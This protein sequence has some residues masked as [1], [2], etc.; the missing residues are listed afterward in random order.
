MPDEQ[1][2]AP[3]QTNTTTTPPANGSA[4]STNGSTPAGAE[5]TGREPMIPRE[6]FDDVN[7][8]LKATEAELKKLQDAA[9][10]AER[11]RQAAEAKALADQGEFKKLYET[12]SGELETAKARAKQADAL[13]A[14]IREMVDTRKANVP[15]HLKPLIEKLDPVEALRWLDAN[16]DK[17][18][19]N[20]APGTNAGERGERGKTPVDP[21][22]VLRRQPY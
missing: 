12:A 9:S 22:K 15:D 19:P 4:G 10:E 7:G 13:E 5:N 14:V 2:A 11:T 18:S 3:A 17:L 8:R 16:A 1:T 21:K 20:P 6:R